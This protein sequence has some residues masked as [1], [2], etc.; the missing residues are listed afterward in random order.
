ML[1][2]SPVAAAIWASP[3]LMSYKTGVIK[4]NVSAVP[5]LNHIVEMIGYDAAGN[6]IIKN[7]W[8]RVWGM[9]GFGYLS[10]RE[11]CAVRQFVAQF[12]EVK[13]GNGNG[14]IAP[15]F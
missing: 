6:W 11:D 5:I 14:S 9:G 2:A 4:C 7:S 3:Q 12:D 10:Q 1:A 13:K 8:G 15:T